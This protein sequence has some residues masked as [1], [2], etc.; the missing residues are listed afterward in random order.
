VVS[1]DPGYVASP[2][3]YLTLKSYYTTSKKR[4][5][6]LVYLAMMMKKNDPSSVMQ[7]TRVGTYPERRPFWFLGGR[8][9]HTQPNLNEMHA[10]EGEGGGGRGKVGTFPRKKYFS[11]KNRNHPPG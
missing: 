1:A 8:W 9:A 3:V 10:M 2:V 5:I 6:A 11:K 7:T 4:P